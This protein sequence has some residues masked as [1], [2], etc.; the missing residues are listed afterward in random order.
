MI[1]DIFVI[2]VTVIMTGKKGYVIL[3][4]KRKLI[5]TGA[6]DLPYH[7]FSRSILSFSNNHVAFPF[8]VAI[9][10]LFTVPFV[11]PIIALFAHRLAHCLRVVRAPFLVAALVICL[12]LERFSFFSSL[13]L[14][15]CV[16]IWFYF[17]VS[18]RCFALNL[19]ARL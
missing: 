8:R 12:P 10:A 3:S 5:M 1:G 2:K 18:E 17:G 6:E 4:E 16:G 15:M 14:H 9:A 11:A 19:V 13:N 7:S